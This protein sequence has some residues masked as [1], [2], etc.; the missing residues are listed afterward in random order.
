MYPIDK[1]LREFIESDVAT[2]VGSAESRERPH[3]VWGWAPRVNDDGVV[4]V[5]LDAARA[6]R[7]IA[8]L[9]VNPRIAMTMAQP[10]S[11]RSVQLKGDFREVGEPNAADKAYV[12]ERREG[13]VTACVLVGDPPEAIRNLWLEEVIRI[14]FSVDQA[15]DQTPGP[16]AGKPL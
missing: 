8:N 10:V 12:Q 1:T 9:R 14:A 11:Y 6:D 4:E 16:N 5:F 2:L 3:V 15:F 7:T 13:F